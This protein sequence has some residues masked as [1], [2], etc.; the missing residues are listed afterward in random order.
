MRHRDTSIQCF[1][2]IK[3]TLGK[4]QKIVLWYIRKFPDHTD[5][6]LAKLMGMKERNDVAPRRCELEHLERIISS[7]KRKCE[8]S[9]KTC[10]TW[11]VKENA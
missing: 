4:R 9:Q 2:E 10:H 11:R 1:R 8:V 5:G 7:G 6:E 3:P